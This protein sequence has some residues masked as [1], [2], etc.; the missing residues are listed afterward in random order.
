MKNKEVKALR[1]PLNLQFFA[2]GNDNGTGTGDGAGDG[3]GTDEGADGG[4][5]TVDDQPKN[6]DDVLKQDTFKAEFDRRVQQAINTALTKQKDKYEALMD[7][8]LS[9]AEKLAK[10][11]KD[12]KQDYLNKKHEKEL[13]DREKAIT[14]R[15]LA[16]EAK[17]TLAEKKLPVSLADVLVY[18]DADSCNKSIEA[19]EKAFTEAVAAAV[20]EKLKGGEPI[21]RGNND[22][23]EYEQVLKLMSGE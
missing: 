4:T 14:R 22:T 21:K 19:V 9:E 12:E 2:D 10:M 1:M 7:D 3:A 23:D 13:A 11:T 20:E 16:A 8:R 6:F 17:N 18:T 15:E 5:D